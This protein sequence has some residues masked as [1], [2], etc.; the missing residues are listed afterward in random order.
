MMSGG[1]SGRSRAREAAA[2]GEWGGRA[3]S[4]GGWRAGLCGVAWRRPW[5]R[6][7]AVNSR[8]PVTIYSRIAWLPGAAAGGRFAVLLPALPERSTH[9]PNPA[10]PLPGCPPLAL[11]PQAQRLGE[12]TQWLWEDLRLHTPEVAGELRPSPVSVTLA[13]LCSGTGGWGHLGVWCTQERLAFPKP[14][15]PGCTVALG[16]PEVKVSRLGRF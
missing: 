9:C 3:A 14:Y 16:V 15:L 4:R 6:C 12:G 8:F 13:V 11:I 1:G 2:P 10:L 5:R 7:V